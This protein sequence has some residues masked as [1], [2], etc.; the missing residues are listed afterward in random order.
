MRKPIRHLL[1]VLGDQLNEDSPLFDDFEP[2][3]DVIWMAEV[4]EESTHVWSH[5][6]RITLFLSAMRHFRQSWESKGA[7]VHYTALSQGLQSTLENE[8]TRCLNDL[9]PHEVRVVLPG[10]YRVRSALQNAVHHA[11][12]SLRILP[13]SH[14]FT[15]PGEFSAHAENRKSLRM[16]F[17]Y[18]EMRKKH[19][20]L[21]D[22][23][24]QPEGGSWNFDAENRKSFGKQGPDLLPRYS[25]PEPDSITRQV[26]SE[27]NKAFPD[28]PGQLDEFIWPV[29]REEALNRLQFFITHILPQ[30]GDYQ[31]AMWTGEPILYHSLLS[32]S[33]NLKLLNPREVVDAA[34]KAYASG[35][36][37][38]PAVEGFIRQI[39]GWR[40]YVR[41]IYW[42]KMPEYLDRNHLQADQDLPDFYWTGETP[43]QCLREA[44]HSTLK[45]GYSHHIHRLMVTGLYSLLLG[46]DPQKIHQ[47]YLAVY[48]DAVEWVELPN[49]LGMSQ[50]ADGGLMASKPYVATGKYI[51]KMSNYCRSCPFNPAE[52]TGPQACPFTTLYWDFL[53]R[54]EDT[55]KSNQRMSLQLRNLTRL[56][57]SRKKA[58]RER[59]GLIRADPSAQS[60]L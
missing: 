9:K 36:A 53:L 26:I 20:I 54:H 24:G 8:L 35:H 38:L 37:P 12:F 40:E 59:A 5:K 49:T 14:F 32:S 19:R 41:G 42:L 45:Y 58:I 55:L 4:G 30:F 6:Q 56:S 51:Q 3:Q 33:L 46:V 50:Y 31:D 7:E 39:L 60:L 2:S 27:V 57:P 21:L 16:E 34:E 13:D 1:I 17:F 10:D 28:H 25:F 18:R 23:K 52:A 29:T 44:L 22:E 47:W 48:V 15:T 11:G 43:Q